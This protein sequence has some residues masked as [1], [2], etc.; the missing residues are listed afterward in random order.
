MTARTRYLMDRLDAGDF[1]VPD[2]G[3]ERHEHHGCRCDTCSAAAERVARL[4]ARLDDES[5]HPGDR[6]PRGVHAP[7][8]STHAAELDAMDERDWNEARRG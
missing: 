4:A 6:Y 3:I 5:R 7:L 1:R 2:H 8:D